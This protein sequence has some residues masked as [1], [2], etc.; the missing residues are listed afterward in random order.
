MHD[1]EIE[2][3]KALYKE[4]GKDPDLI[5]WSWENEAH[6]HIVLYRGVVIHINHETGERELFLRK[7][8]SS[9]DEKALHYWENKLK[10]KV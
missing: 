6:N 1:A 9:E 4:A 2:G 8:A 3:V 7:K 5:I 10:Q